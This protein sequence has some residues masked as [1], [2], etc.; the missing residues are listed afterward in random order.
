MSDFAPWLKQPERDEKPEYDLEDP[1][2]LVNV[3]KPEEP[4][5]PHVDWFLDHLMI[6]PEKTD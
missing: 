2:P 5:R 3:L 6:E 1:G 4:T